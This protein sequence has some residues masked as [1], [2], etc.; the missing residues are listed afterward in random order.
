MTRFK[1][2][3]VARRILGLEK[4]ATIEKIKQK[5]R[6]LVLRYHPDMCKDSEKRKCEKMYKKIN[7]AYG[8][9]MTYCA[10]YKYSFKKE[11]IERNKIDKQTYEYLKQ[12]H[13]GWWEDLKQ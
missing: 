1:K 5:H 7:D 9:L 6:K 3:D 10:G 11:A 8:I 2:I 4:T 13:D 12:F